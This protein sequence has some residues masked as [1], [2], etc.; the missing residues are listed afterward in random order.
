MIGAGVGLAADPAGKVVD[1]EGKPVA[2]V[3]VAAIGRNWDDPAVTASATTGADGRFVLKGAWTLGE[4]DLRYLAVLARAGDGR[5]GWVSTVWR[6]QPSA[7]D[8]VIELGDT[9]EV[10]GQLIDQDG[11]PLPHILVRPDILDRSRS[12]ERVYDQLALPRS[13]AGPYEARTDA[14]G[15]FALKGIPRR[16]RLRALIDDPVV[17][18]PWVFWDPA[19][20]SKLVLDR[21]LGEITGR[22]IVPRGGPLTGGVKLGL[23]RAGGDPAKEA[24]SLTVT[25]SVPVEE[26]GRFKAAGLPPGAYSLRPELGPDVPYSE[27]VKASVTLEPGKP[28][29]ALEI[30]MP[31]R[32]VVR[33]RV[34]DEAT[35]RGIADVGLVAYRIEGYSQRYGRRAKTDAAGRFVVAV[36]PG[37]TKIH[38]DVPPKGYV[39][40]YEE[41][42]PRLEVKQDRDWPDFKLARAAEIDGRVVDPAGKPVA[43]AEVRLVVPGFRG[44]MGDDRLVFA[45]TDGSFWLE[46]LDPTDKVPVR[47]RTAD[48]TTDG[49][50]VIRPSELN[51]P[52][53]LT[54]TVG[55]QF[56][57]RLTGRVV[58]QRGKPVTNAPISV[59][60]NRSLVSEKAMKGMGLGSLL[61]QVRTG[62]DGRFRTAALWP[63]DSYHVTV[64]VKPY[65]KSETPQAKL[66]AGEVRDVGTIALVETSAAVAGRVVGSDGK[67]IAGAEVFNRGDGPRPVSTR[68]GP[69]GRFRLEGLFAGSKFA[70]ARRDG[71]R[72]GRLADA[73]KIAQ[74]KYV[75]VRKDGYRFAGVA[76]DGEPQDVTI[77]LL[78]HEE[79]PTPWKPRTGDSYEDQKSLAKRTLERTWERL[80]DGVNQRGWVLARQMTLIDA[81][82]AAAWSAQHG[83][84]FDGEIRRGRAALLA[85][86]DAAA[87]IRELTE[88][89]DNLTPYTL[90][91]IAERLVESAPDKAALLAE[92][93]AKRARGIEGPDRATALARAGSVLYRVGRHDAGRKIVEEAVQ[94]ASGFKVDERS[95]YA[96]AVA[97]KALA[98]LDLDRALALIEPI[99]ERRDRDRYTGFLIDAIGGS[100]PDR[101]I[102]LL[103]TLEANSSL[104][105]TLTTGIA[106]AIAPRQP[107]R[108]VRLV[109]GMKGYQPEKHQAEAFGWLALAIAPRDRARAFALVDRALALPIDK[110]EP[111]GSYTYFGAAL[112]SSAGIAL[113]ARRIGY[114]DME[115]VVMRVMAAR[116]DGQHGFNDPAMQAQAA[117]IAA[118]LV[119]LLDPSAAAT[120]LGQIEAR[121]GLSQAALASVTGEWWLAA[122]ALADVK[123]AEGIVEAQLEALK[124]AREPDQI[125]HGLSKMIEVL[126]IPPRR[127]EAELRRLIGAAWRPAFSTSD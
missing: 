73:L 118:P 3:A 63:G 119:A 95:S 126:I 80:G 94:F 1:A 99:K 7:H 20:V 4:L 79:T 2:G 127:R 47:A 96:R 13:L 52:G 62:P 11:R 10:S 69:D 17:G 78:K 35:G 15:R 107:D 5:C 37:T 112:A 23:S 36:E 111:F 48:A 88:K 53:K 122:W 104:P 12:E 28:S 90:Q 25:R 8:L 72:Y 117:T 31:R 42:C 67:P 92:E 91:D 102:A 27:D 44:F 40:I 26:D 46:Q 21:R 125:L 68:T 87:A 16:A 56:A 58:D 65:A 115:G 14:D 59:L 98:P 9:A 120:V 24:L 34:I 30:A 93:A 38:P 32:P 22:L 85:E 50:I 54:V 64:D 60:W 108:A 82:Q 101:A 70:F 105:E 74:R 123:H 41:H 33:G 6:E 124:T 103:E 18:R 39:G 43:E 75:F 121:S 61:D 100:S 106:F 57:A 81:D 71:F 51:P 109:E 83:N 19:K 114:P 110:P 97:A 76:V 45:G 29:A 89:A 55:P 49:A 86:T 77:R 84:R 116:V 66:S 113:N